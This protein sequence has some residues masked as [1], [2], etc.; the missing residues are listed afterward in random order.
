MRDGPVK[1]EFNI[2]ELTEANFPREVLESRYPVLVEIG[3]KWCG[4]C[5]IMGQIIQQLSV[6]YEGLIRIG[7]LDFDLHEQFSRKYGV[8]KIP[9]LLFFINGHLCDQIIGLVSKKEIETR[10]RA[11]LQAKDYPDQP[12]T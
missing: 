6:E 9:F 8:T 7:F 2:I 3:A 5:H 10:L 12:P 1:K 4:N 11:L